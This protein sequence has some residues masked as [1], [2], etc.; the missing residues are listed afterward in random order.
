M[1]LPETCKAETP[2]ED[3]TISNRQPSQRRLG[4]FG[5]YSR[6]QKKCGKLY[7]VVQKGA[8]FGKPATTIKFILYKT[9]QFTP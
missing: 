2:V 7:K 6:F 8:T 5:R 1:I 4:R 9:Q 3:L